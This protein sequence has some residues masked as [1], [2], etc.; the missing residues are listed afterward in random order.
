MENTQVPDYPRGITFEQVW[1]ALMEDRKR[2]DELKESQQETG[3]QLKEIQEETGRF[4]KELGRQMGDL[5]NTF[6][7]IAEHLVAPGIAERFNELG[8]HFNAVS[9]GGH[10][11][12]DDNGKT[13][14]E[15]DILLENRYCI[16]AVEVKTKPKIQDIEHH[17]K[18][19]EILRE[20][21]N[22]LNDKRIIKGAIAGAIFGSTEKQAVLEAGLY[23]IVQSGDTM[24]LDLSEGFVSRE[25]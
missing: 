3:R 20:H 2:M 15:I 18:R 7:E 8:Y 12:L 25:W 19:L 22:K 14:T 5:H 6:G 16:M 9:P 13:R 4:I 23:V 10:K 17:I 24:M 21:R 11:I 1:A